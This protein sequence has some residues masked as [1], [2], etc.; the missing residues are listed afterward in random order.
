MGCIFRAYARRNSWTDR[1]QILFGYRDPGRNY[2]YQIWWRSVKRF[3]VGEVPKFALSHRLC[4]SSLQQCY[5][6]SCTV[7]FKSLNGLLCADVQLRNYS[8]TQLAK[9]GCLL[10]T[11]TYIYIHRESAATCLKNSSMSCSVQRK[12]RL[13]VLAGWLISAE[14][15][16][17]A[18]AF[19]LSMLLK[20]QRQHNW[21][22]TL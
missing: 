9:T 15:T 4:R 1:F 2:V 10:H 19:A 12:W 3:L 22:S 20:A 14:W 18:R 5:A 21:R 6:T 8:L 16:I 7:I 17:S 13:H 11:H